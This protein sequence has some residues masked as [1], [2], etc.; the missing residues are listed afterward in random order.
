MTRFL[1]FVFAFIL[2]CSMSPLQAQR[3]ATSRLLPDWTLGLI[4]VTDSTALSEKFAKTGFSQMLKDEELKPFLESVYGSTMQLAEGIE[5]SIG[6]TIDQILEIPE[7]ELLVAMVAPPAFGP[8]PLLMMDLPE[9][10]DTV[11]DLLDH[12]AE[13]LRQNGYSVEDQDYEGVDLEVYSGDGDGPEN[14]IRFE[15]DGMLV[16]AI[17]MRAAERIIDNWQGGD[18]DSLQDNQ[19]YKAIAARCQ[20]GNGEEADIFFFADP[21]GIAKAAA[22]GNIGAAAGLAFLPAIGLDGFQGFGGSILYPE[23]EFESVAHWHVYL[24]N[25]RDGILEMITLK[26]GDGEPEEWAPKDLITYSTFHFDLQKTYSILK[27]LVDSFREEGSLAK[28]I[29]ENISDRIGIDFEQDFI[30]QLQGRVTMIQVYEEPPRLNSQ[31]TAIALKMRDRDRFETALD[32]VT[33]QFS[34]FLVQRTISGESVFRIGSEEDDEESEVE[35]EDE[36]RRA[37][38]RRLRIQSRPKPTFVL[39]DDYLIF[40]DRPSTIENFITAKNDE[41]Q[42]LTAAEDFQTVMENM[43]RQPGGDS[44]CVVAFSR[45]AEAMGTLYKLL[46][47]DDAL[48]FI[49]ARRDENPAF[50]I[51]ADA[52]EEHPLPPFSRLEKFFPATGGLM[53]NEET[54][55]H[56]FSFALRYEDDEE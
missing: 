14:I 27:D 42:R 44:A 47:S 54:G 18:E 32:T 37:R 48:E 30:A 16:I 1:T 6:M 35:V 17:D 33:D 23:S 22:R 29:K 45:P 13:V 43:S 24:E 12:G 56:S 21:I 52:L 20:A 11:S 3:P 25:P 49:K 10:T 4:R 46:A 36:D 53:T 8:S 7:G 40:A 2:T 55:I 41:E 31:S 19:A 5:Q 28:L 26:D 9:D 38:E 15:K 51:L 50:T 39:L 34:D